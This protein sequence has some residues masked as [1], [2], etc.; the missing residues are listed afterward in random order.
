M[1]KEHI[2]PYCYTCGVRRVGIAILG[3]SCQCCVCLMEERIDRLDAKISKLEA[4][5]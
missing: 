4:R 2:E 1:K 5:K 3:T